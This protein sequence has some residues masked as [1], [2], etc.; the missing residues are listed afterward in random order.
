[1]RKKEV[2]IL[3][4]R[5]FGDSLNGKALAKFKIERLKLPG[6]EQ[7]F[8]VA[9]HRH[10]YYHILFITNG[11]GQH[12]IDFETYEIKPNA[13]FFVSPGQVHSL[14]VDKDI[15]GYVITFNSD[16]YL[17]NNSVQ[18]LLD[19]PFFHSLSNTP[20]IYLSDE[21]VEIRDAADDLYKE[22]Q[23]SEKGRENMLRALLEVF[24]IR[25][26]RLYHHPL[27]SQTPKHLAY[28]LRKLEALIDTHFK[29]YKMLDDYAGM[30]FISSKHLNSLCKKGLNK[31]VTNL[32]HDRALLEAKRM[33]LF[34]NNSIAEIAFDLGFTNKSYF[35]KF[36]KK[37][38]TLT[39]NEYRTQNN[40]GYSK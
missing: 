11:L 33:L 20:V 32:I 34:T 7:E 22:Y 16:F 40:M 29:T 10:D 23:S 17:L 31:T 28:Q 27:A 12:T 39:A 1:M 8:K 24:L 21:A 14:E 36:F 26:S 35:M 18:K 15:D 25:A 9:A 38:T 4:V 37:H 30:M 6:E 5:S 2:N 13:I 3:P 19:Y